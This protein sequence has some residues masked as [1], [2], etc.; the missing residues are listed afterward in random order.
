MLVKTV[1]EISKIE[2][3]ELNF[4]Q[5][6][7][8]DT[9]EAAVFNTNVLKKHDFDFEKAVE[10]EKNSI[11]TP[12][13][14]FRHI[15]NIS[16]IWKFRE[17]W[18]EIRSI[19]TK[20]VEYP[21]M[22][23]Q[24]ED[25]RKE[26]LKKM[27]ER[28]NHKSAKKQENFLVLQKITRKEVEQGFT[29]PLTQE[30]LFQLKGAAVI[31]M[32]VHEQ[33][34]IN[35]LG[36]RIM[37]QRACHDASFPTPSGY[38]VNLDHNSD[39]LSPCI[40]GQCLRRCL[41]SIHIMRSTHENTVIYIIK[42]DFDAAYRRVHVCPAH[43]VKTMILVGSLVYLLS[44][45][46]FG[47]EAGPSKYS[48]ISEGIF[49]LGNDLLDDPSW[50][51]DKV[52]SPVQNKLPAKEK[53]RKGEKFGE[54]KELCV[55]I[56]CREASCDGYIDDAIL[57][58][59]DKEEN[60][61]RAQNA[62]PLAAHCIFRPLAKFEPIGRNDTICERKFEAEGTPRESQIVLGWLVDTR[63]FKIY[64]P[65]DKAVHWTAELQ[66]MLKD[67]Y[68]ITTKEIEST[69]GRLNHVGYI[70]PHGRFFLN[71]L[72]RLLYRCQKFGSQFANKMEKNDMKLWLKMLTQASQIG[73]SINLITFVKNDELIYTDACETGLG[74]YNPRTGRAWRYRLPFWMQRQF[75]INILE[76]IASLIGIWMEIKFSNTP[77]LSI[78]AKTDNSSALGWL[79]KSNFDPDTHSRHDQVARKMAEILLDSETVLYPKHVR[80]EQNIIADSLSRDQHIPCKKHAL[81]L[82]SLYPEQTPMGLS[83]SEDLP[84]DITYW[85]ESL[86]GGNT[87]NEVSP[88]EPVP[89]KMGALVSGDVS[90][91]AVASMIN[92]WKAT[93]PKPELVWSAPLQ[94]LF[95]EM[96]MGREISINFQEK[97]LDKPSITYVRPLE[98]TF[99]AAP[100]SIKT[101]N[102]PSSSDAK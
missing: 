48:A 51:P 22:Q 40:Y 63:S 8:E 23:E 34:T 73:V 35:E 101:D 12:G 10:S 75:H 79:V 46:P 70:M 77:Y 6:L 72:R 53:P 42:Y 55:E 43:A 24:H 59:L 33:Y 47:V 54:A 44:R 13:S 91:N 96:N 32:G 37:K 66:N 71:R 80:G 20:G 95:A 85:L 94:R 9:E 15:D 61:K 74:G 17:N 1:K 90:W 82:T 16:K 26:D 86:K 102:H 5:F 7:F 64:L 41:H 89:S 93:A 57:I 98:Q 39:L 45:L 76:F 100:C 68:R 99:I 65:V 2:E 19:L 25:I 14:E 49:D 18:E 4:S 36:E 92:F 67:N 88:R 56:K 11:L 27:V 31:P 78:L 69:I 21:L 29:F 97:P 28:G 58:A 62:I 84:Q 50:D 30:G 81:F 38:S 83:I 52:Y 60:A 87:K 3:D